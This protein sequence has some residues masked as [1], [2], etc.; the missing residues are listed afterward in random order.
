MSGR[1]DDSFK[2]MKE[3]EMNEIAEIDH[4][5][6]T[7]AEHSVLPVIDPS[8]AMVSV[9][10]RMMTD[11]SVP[12]ERLEKAMDMFE[13]LQAQQAEKAFNAALAASQAEMPQIAKNRKNL[14]TKSK[15][16][17]LAAINE[18]AQ[19]IYGKHGLSVSFSTFKSEFPGHYGVQGTL[20]HADGHSKVYPA[21]IPADTGGM[22]GNT[23]KTATQAFGST[24]SYGQRYLVCLIFNI[25]TSMDDDGNRS[26]NKIEYIN[27]TQIKELD[28]LLVDTNSD[29]EK[30]L[31]YIACD[32]LG[33]IPAEFFE[34]QK[35]VIANAANKRTE[36]KT[37][38]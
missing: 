22:K 7:P 11:Q 16:S 38:D 37:D 6:K 5:D 9:L 12:M 26:S 36:E 29:K 1:L 34:H 18:K 24:M 31:N 15:Y 27:E 3:I 17:D 4:D 20:S 30:Y 25:A 28:K 8:T 32:E 14:H 21:D 23:N 19:P 35:T 2:D 33:D 13:R 10:E